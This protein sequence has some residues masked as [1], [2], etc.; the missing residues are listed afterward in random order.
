MGLFDLFKGGNGASAPTAVADDIG[1]ADDLIAQG[2][3]LEDAG[4]I[5]A[6]LER[7]EAAVAC[8]PGHA[9]AH[10]NVGN[11]RLAQG[12]ALAA[13]RAYEQALLLRNDYAPA[14]FNMGNTYA[15]LGRQS[16][17]MGC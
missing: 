5:D 11:A 7:Y 3:A 14:H 17:A 6:A 8:A 16:E 4:R 13:L 9:R 15:G 12:D 2:H 1:Q 10:L